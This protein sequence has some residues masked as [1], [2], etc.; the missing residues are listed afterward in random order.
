[1]GFILVRTAT[2]RGV[3]SVTS[4]TKTLEFCM[5]RMSVKNVGK[6]SQGKDQAEG[7]VLN[8]STLNKMLLLMYSSTQHISML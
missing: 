8:V 5:L 1:M 2:Y 4:V 3:C 6:K 7:S